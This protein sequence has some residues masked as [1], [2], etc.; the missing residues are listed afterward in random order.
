MRR[1]QNTK[2]RLENERK[3]EIVQPVSSHYVCV[4]RSEKLFNVILSFFSFFFSQ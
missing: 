2:K 3:A 4:C 1:E